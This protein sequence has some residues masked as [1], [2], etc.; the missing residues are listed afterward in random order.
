[1]KRLIRHRMFKLIFFITFIYSLQKIHCTIRWIMSKY[2]WKRHPLTDSL[3][4]TLSKYSN[5]CYT[6]ITK[7]CYINTTCTKWRWCTTCTWWTKTFS[8]RTKWIWTCSKS[9]TS[10]TNTIN[11]FSD[12]TKSS[13]FRLETN[14]WS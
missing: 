4:C 14:D 2:W 1:M 6:S 5:V 8:R 10:L 3:F 12:K 7:L 9:W 11:R 13:S